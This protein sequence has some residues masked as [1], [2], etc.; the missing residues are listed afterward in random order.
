MAGLP[1]AE[2]KLR[3]VLWKPLPSSG[4]VLK[5]NHL[6]GDTTGGR[7]AR[8]HPLRNPLKLSGKMLIVAALTSLNSGHKL[9]LW[10]S[11]KREILWKL[12]DLLKRNLNS[13]A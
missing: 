8:P 10:K 4:T 7:Q 12:D 2:P 3:I 13:K 6:M 5:L 9:I 11:N 1:L